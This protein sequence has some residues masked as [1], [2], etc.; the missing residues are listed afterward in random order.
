MNTNKI[1]VRY[2]GY[3]T[4]ISKGRFRV[5]RFHG[6]GHMGTPSPRWNALGEP[7]ESPGELDV[8]LLIFLPIRPNFG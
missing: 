7:S 2:S 3:Y 8:H 4:S 5:L 1:L 6:D